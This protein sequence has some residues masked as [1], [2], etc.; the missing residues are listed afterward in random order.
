MKDRA[1]PHSGGWAVEEIRVDVGPVVPMT[2]AGL[3]GTNT[4]VGMDGERI[5]SAARTALAGSGSETSVPELWD[6]H[7]AERI[8]RILIET[9]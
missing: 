1:P 4:V 6:G 2:M 3:L 9:G 7:A 8:A 5:V